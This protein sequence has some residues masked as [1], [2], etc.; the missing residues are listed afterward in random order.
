MNDL[1]GEPLKPEPQKPPPITKKSPAYSSF[2][3]ST[4]RP[5][6]TFR[7]EDKPNTTWIINKDIN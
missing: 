4:T 5:Y 1:F 3:L 7:S 6:T 2:D